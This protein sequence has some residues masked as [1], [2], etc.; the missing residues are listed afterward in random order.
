MVLIPADL[1]AAV[2]HTAGAAVIT[3]GS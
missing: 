2:R 1:H 3:G